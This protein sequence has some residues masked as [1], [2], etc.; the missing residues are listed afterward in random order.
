MRTAINTDAEKCYQKFQNSQGKELLAIDHFAEESFS[1]SI[2]ASLGDAVAVSGE[3]SLPR[4]GVD[5]S[6]S[7]LIHILCDM[8]DGTDL[9]VRG[10]SNWCSAFIAFEP[11]TRQILA[12][13][14]YVVD[15]GVDVLYSAFVDKEGSHLSEYRTY[16]FPLNDEEFVKFEREEFEFVTDDQVYARSFFEPSARRKLAE[17]GIFSYGQKLK[18]FRALSDF[19][20]HDRVAEKIVKA[21]DLRIYNLAGNPA[22]CRM[23]EGKVDLVFDLAGQAAHDVLPGAFIALKAGA[24]MY[25]LDDF[26][27]EPARRL[28]SNDLIEFAMRPCSQDT[29]LKYFVASNETLA[30]EFLQLLTDVH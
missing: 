1:K 30:N 4:T 5:Y 17:A 13:H 19:L 8:I 11:S 24:V 7:N 27:G 6:G 25:L 18:N 9:L 3:E 28:Q 20:L 16:V 21:K 10:L 22:L 12:S 23:V 29:R 14:V 26:P 15:R 2:S